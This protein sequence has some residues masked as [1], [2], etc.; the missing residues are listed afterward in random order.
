MTT[1]SLLMLAAISHLGDLAAPGDQD[2]PQYRRAQQLRGNYIG[3]LDPVSLVPR[4]KLIL[5]RHN[6]SFYQNYLVPLE[7]L[8]QRGLNA[9]EHLLRRAFLWF[10]QR[11]RDRVR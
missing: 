7:K 5:N 10:K 2:D 1:L 6:D 9:S 11:I 4:S 3:Y 8:P